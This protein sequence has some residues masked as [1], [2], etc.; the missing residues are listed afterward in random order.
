MKRRS[1]Y[2]ALISIFCVV[3]FWYLHRNPQ[4]AVRTTLFSAGFFKTSWQADI[5]RAQ[6][7]CYLVTPAPIETET[8]A[9]LV[10]YQVKKVGCFYF[11]EYYG[12]A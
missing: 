9:A 11:A 3:G 12:E 5:K 6:G 4:A 7:S 2:V 10:S 1:K 8:K